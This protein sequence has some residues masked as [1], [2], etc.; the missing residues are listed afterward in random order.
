MKIGVLSDT[1]DDLA[2]T[3][4]ALGLLL[5]RDAE[6][7]IHCGDI[8]GPDI[9][10]VC[11]QSP[12]WFVYGNHDSD[13]VPRLE[14]AC[15]DPNLHSLGWGGEIELAGR[16]IAVTHGHM[17]MDVKPLL[18]ARPHYLLTGHFHEAADWTEHGVRRVCPGA[19]HRATPRTVAL[20][21]LQTTAVEF[22]EVR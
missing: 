20:L 16:R 12:T 13:C 4:H 15:H 14:A 2:A 8:T 22:L 17:T 10:R 9:L 6:A 19:L 7:F 5:S 21:D 1:H 18:A 3:E 11:S